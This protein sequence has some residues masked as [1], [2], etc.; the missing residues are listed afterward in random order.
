MPSH[1]YIQV[2]ISLLLLTISAMAQVEKKN[3]SINL[4]MTDNDSMHIITATVTDSVTAKPLQKVEITFYVQRMFGLMK[5][6]N[7]T[8]DTTGTVTAEFPKNTRADETGKVILIAKVED[9]DVMN[10]KVIQ[11]TIKPD[12]P[13]LQNKAVSRAMIGH[14]APWWLVITFTLTVGTVSLLF[15]YV[16]YLVY[17]IKKASAVKIIS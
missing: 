11:K 10:D 1:K 2:A 7:S 3:G 13:H 16:L 8:S 14:F 6:G 17:R 15:V 12:L 4:E 9:N 5:V